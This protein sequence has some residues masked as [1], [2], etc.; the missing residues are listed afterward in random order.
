MPTEATYRLSGRGGANQSTLRRTELVEKRAPAARVQRFVGPQLF[1]ILLYKY[2]AI[3]AVF[4]AI[5]TNRDDVQSNRVAR[6]KFFG[7][8][9]RDRGLC[10]QP[11]FI[12]AFFV[13]VFCFV[14]VSVFVRVPKH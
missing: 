9:F 6:F 1:L 11:I 13:K 7:K 10:P 14:T 8:I 2:D 5:A 4:G 3:N 12:I